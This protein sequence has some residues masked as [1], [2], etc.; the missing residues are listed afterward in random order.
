M[1]HIASNKTCDKTQY[2]VKSTVSF[3]YRLAGRLRR[4]SGKSYSERHDL[5]RA[6]DQEGN[7]LD[8]WTRVAR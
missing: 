8:S 4:F 5:W 6:V 7:V 1:P 3:M 2:G